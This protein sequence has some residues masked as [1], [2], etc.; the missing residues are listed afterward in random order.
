MDI[1]RNLPQKILAF[2]LGTGY[3]DSKNIIHLRR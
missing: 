1:V 3:T 2:F